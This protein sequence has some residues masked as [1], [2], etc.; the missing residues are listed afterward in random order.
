MNEIILQAC[1]AKIL[2]TNRLI[3]F[4]FAV[5]SYKADGEC[6]QQCIFSSSHQ[7]KSP[8]C[9][10]KVGCLRKVAMNLCE[11]IWWTLRFMAPL[12]CLVTKPPS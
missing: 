3:G 6:N 2:P 7:M 9:E 4:S 1:D 10:Q 5:F 11:L 8:Q 12:L